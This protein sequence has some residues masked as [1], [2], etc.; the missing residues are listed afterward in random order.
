M[1]LKA[2]ESLAESKSN[3]QA[4]LSDDDECPKNSKKRRISGSDTLQYLCE[5]QKMTEN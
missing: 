3:K 1:R 2:M 5:K 4:S